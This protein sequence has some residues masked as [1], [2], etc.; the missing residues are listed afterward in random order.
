[1]APKLVE[2][3]VTNAF[4]RLWYHSTES[5]KKNTFL[6]FGVQQ[7]PFD[8]QL[9]QELVFNLKPRF[10][11]Q[12][13]VYDGGSLLFFAHMLDLIGSPPEVPVV[14]VDITLRDSAKQLQHPRIT[15][16]EGS[17]VAPEVVARVK[18]RVGDQGPCLVSLDSDHTQKHVFA[19]MEAYGPLVP[20]G[21][22][23]V[24]ED[25]NINGHPVYPDFGPGPYEAVEQYLSLHDD[26]ERD[27]A[28]WQRNMFSFHQYGWLKKIK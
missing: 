2:R 21:S 11:V 9:Y 14:G 13:G 1:M 16:I 22:Y 8:L 26:F 4:H 27:D 24:V 7:C 18:Q 10:I 25:T 19:E 20:K 12:T 17:S 6:G 28:L 3:W 5:W 23:L 15:L